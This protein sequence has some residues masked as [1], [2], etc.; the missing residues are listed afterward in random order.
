MAPER[1]QRRLAAILAADIVGYSWLLGADE[2]GTLAAVKS[3]IAEAFDL[4]HTP[5]VGS[6]LIKFEGAVQI[7]DKIRDYA[8]LPEDARLTPEEVEEIRALGDNTGCMK[9]KG[10]SKRHDG[11]CERPDEWPM[12]EDL[13]QLASQYEL[14]QEW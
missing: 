1:V 8:S 14:T 9:L 4:Q 12:R 11:P 2:E 3:D 5:G 6:L 13:L 7:E 10:A